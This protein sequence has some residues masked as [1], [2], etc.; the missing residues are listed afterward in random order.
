MNIGISVRKGNVEL[1]NKINDVVG[2]MTKD[3]FNKMMSDATKI[4]PLSES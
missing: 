2:K 3:D 4:Q 1:K